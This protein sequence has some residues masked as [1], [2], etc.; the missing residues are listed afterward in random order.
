M[1]KI[2]LPLLTNYFFSRFKDNPPTNTFISKP[3][4]HLKGKHHLSFSISP[5]YFQSLPL[6]LPMVVT[7]QKSHPSL[8]MFSFIIFRIFIVRRLRYSEQL[9]NERDNFLILLGYMLTKK[10]KQENKIKH[11]TKSKQNK[12]NK[13]NI[14]N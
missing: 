8:K 14:I 10:S 1:R 2:S 12:D 13:Y 11:Q 4:V 7:R 6:Q 9:G 3:S 5:L